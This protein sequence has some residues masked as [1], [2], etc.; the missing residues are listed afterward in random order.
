[1]MSEAEKK[2]Q[3]WRHERVNRGSFHSQS[4]YNEANAKKDA[5][6]L[7]VLRNEYPNISA[8]A[9]TIQYRLGFG[10]VQANVLANKY[11]MQKQGLTAGQTPE[12]LGI[13]ERIACQ[14]RISEQAL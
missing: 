4:E 7:G 5:I 6:Q 12:Q 8:V 2:I 3:Q 10:T 14:I 11:W 1:M 9:I 13:P